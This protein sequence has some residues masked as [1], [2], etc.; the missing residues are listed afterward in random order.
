MHSKSLTRDKDYYLM[1]DIFYASHFL[2]LVAMLS[3]SS[4]LNKH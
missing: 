2:F 3:L 4:L 1:L